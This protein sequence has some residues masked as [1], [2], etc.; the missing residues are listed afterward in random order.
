MRWGVGITYC[1]CGEA[2]DESDAAVG[3]EVDCDGGLVAGEEVGSGWRR[4]VGRAVDAQ[5]GSAGVCEEHA[6]KG[7]WLIRVSKGSA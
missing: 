1:V 2:A 7:A 5:D 3:F 6:G 4:R